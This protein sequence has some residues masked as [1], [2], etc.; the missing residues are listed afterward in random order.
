MM[1]ILIFIIL[2]LVLVV[3]YSTPSEK[4]IIE[5]LDYPANSSCS[6]CSVNKLKSKYKTIDPTQGKTVFAPGTSPTFGLWKSFDDVPIRA[7]AKTSMPQTGYIPCNLPGL[8]AVRM[9]VINQ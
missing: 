9:N 2:I 7:C 6:S 3:I 1:E 8:Q 4:T 5:I